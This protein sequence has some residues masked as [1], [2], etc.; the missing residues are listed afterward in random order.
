MRSPADYEHTK[1][2]KNTTY[3]Q[4]GGVNILYIIHNVC[5]D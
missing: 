4:N 5:T 3:N 2:T 1:D